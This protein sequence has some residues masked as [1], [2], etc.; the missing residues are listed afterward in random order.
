M[1]SPFPN[2]PPALRGEVRTLFHDSR[3]L[4]GNPWGDP[5]TREVQVLLPA[6]HRV[7]PDRPLPVVLVL[8]GYAGTGE[9]LLA[10]GL[11][12]VSLAS[13]VDALLAGRALDLPATAAPPP[14][15]IAVLPDVMSRLG[16]GQYVDSPA[17]GRYAS[18]LGEELPAWI[19]GQFATTGRWGVT[20]RS[21]GGFGALHLAAA[22]PGRFQAVACQSG[23]MGFDLAYLGELSHAVGPLR[24]AGGPMP[25]VERFWQERA[26]TGG[27]FSALSLLCLAAAYTPLDHA[28]A[29]G[30]PAPLP[31]DLD[32]GAVDFAL[33]EAWRRF[34]PVVRIEDPAVRAAFGALDLLWLDCGDRDE[35]HLHLGAR[36][37]T[38]R[39]AALGI[40]HQYEEYSGGHRGT[41]WRTDAALDALAR[42]LGGGG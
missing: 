24:A 16:G 30:F 26:P 34:D 10:R 4:Q 17:L 35:H 20:G 14:P 27:A 18:W 21:S 1:P 36:R 11:S 28:L 23:D 42:A 32:T 39:L 29:G 38:G 12:D 15:F 40:A 37:F 3:A 25:F 6:A 22:H 33:F 9:K 19:A 8:A 5:A 41:T 2:L 31:V 7:D 13:R